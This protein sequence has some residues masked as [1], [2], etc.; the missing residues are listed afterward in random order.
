MHAAY[1][2][3]KVTWKNEDRVPLDEFLKGELNP[4]CILES[5]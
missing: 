2:A 4:S 3:R 1:V 5:P